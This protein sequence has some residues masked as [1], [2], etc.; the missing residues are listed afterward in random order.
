M[1][2]ADFDYPL[3]SQ[4]I[5]QAPLPE[6]DASRL[7]V[8]PR[9]SGPVEHRMVRDLPQLLQ[10]GDL[11]VANDARVIPARL[12]GRKAGTG[13]KVELLLVE[14]LGGAG[15]LALGQSSK[16]LRAGAVGEGLGSAVQILGAR[17]GGAS[18]V[19]LP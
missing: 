6:R 16:P 11:L 2:V 3:P 5:A 4:L 10:A 12:R 18:V 7:L 19:R 8:L 14:P 17:G 15:W 13:G 9:T 1:D